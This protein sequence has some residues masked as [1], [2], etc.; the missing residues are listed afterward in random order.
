MK[1]KL[2][3]GLSQEKHQWLT[4]TVPRL[5]GAGLALGHIATTSNCTIP[6]QGKCSTCGSCIIAIGSLMT[7]AL[8]KKNSSDNFYIDKSD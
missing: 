1:Q 6:Q 4:Q 5:A 3:A 7:W 2:M 8:A